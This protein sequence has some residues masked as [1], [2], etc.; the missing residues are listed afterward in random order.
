MK[1]SWQ[2]Q[3]KC[4]PWKCPISTHMCSTYT[5]VFTAQNGHVKT[6][7]DWHL[8]NYTVTFVHLLCQDFSFLFIHPHICKWYSPTDR[9]I[10]YKDFR[11]FPP[12]LIKA[13]KYVLASKCELPVFC[14]KLQK[15]VKPV[16]SLLGQVKP[17]LIF[18]CLSFMVNTHTLRVN[19]TF[20]VVSKK[21][22]ACYLCSNIQYVT[23]FLRWFLMKM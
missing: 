11:R 10:F 9:H 15:W 3:L 16:N 7:L 12:L 18:F 22:G 21:D 6:E 4:L 20:D 8:T 23:F 19:K 2:W 13:E 17:Q 5:G 14:W 1:G